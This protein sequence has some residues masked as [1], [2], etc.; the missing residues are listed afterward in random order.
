MLA[1]RLVAWLFLPLSLCLELLVVGLLLLWFT[2]RKRLAKILI[3]TGTGLLILFSF[4]PFSSLL[5]EPVE[6]THPPLVGQPG[7]AGTARW[8]VVLGSGYRPDP[9]Q[10]ATSRLPDS[11]LVRLTEGVRVYRSVPGSKLLVLIGGADAGDGRVETVAELA[12]AFGVPPADL[13]IDATGRTT[14]EEA[15][16][17]R[18]KVGTSPFV[19]VTSAYH[20][21]RAVQ[22]CRDRGLD[23]IPAPT[24]YSS[25]KSEYSTL[26]A[27]PSPGNLGRA[28]LA[29]SEALAR[30]WRSL[31]GG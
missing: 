29:W 7:G 21:P 24:N 14:A 11:G 10:P 4:G 9:T 18:A 8:V 19:L 22:L 12:A 13:V 1:A 27:L 26:N 30:V 25:A 17:I 23:P 3:T 16:V 2:R 5:V 28:H 20:M 6:T 31:G 15:D